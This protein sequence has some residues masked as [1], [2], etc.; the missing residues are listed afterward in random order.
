MSTRLLDVFGQIATVW[1]INLK[2]NLGTDF[3]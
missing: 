3:R 2:K 1:G